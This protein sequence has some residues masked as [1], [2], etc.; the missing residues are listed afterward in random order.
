VPR[1]LEILDH[2]PGADAGRIAT[3]LFFETVDTEYTVKFYTD[4]D[5][6]CLYRFQALPFS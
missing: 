4:L 3:N 6:V 5:F 1:Q 2:F